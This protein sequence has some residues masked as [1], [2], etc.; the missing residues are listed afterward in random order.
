MRTCWC[1][2]MAEHLIR[3]E[4]VEGSTPSISS[5]NWPRKATSGAFAILAF[6]EISMDSAFSL[7]AIQRRKTLHKPT[8][9]EKFRGMHWG[10]IS[11]GEALFPWNQNPVF[12]TGTGCT[13]NTVWN[14]RTAPTFFCLLMGRHLF[15]STLRDKTAIFMKKHPTDVGYFSTVMVVY[16]Q[17]RFNSSEQLLSIMDSL[18][19]RKQ[20][21]NAAIRTIADGILL[22]L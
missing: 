15:F 7:P 10:Y 1:S 13:S 6:D 21:V 17:N 16:Q 2:L 22:I 11:I 20:Q 12:S 14:S 8:R 5:K 19:H 3:N 4:K 18:I 9:L